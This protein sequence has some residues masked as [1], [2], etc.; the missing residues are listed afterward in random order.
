M[1]SPYGA[2]ARVPSSITTTAITRNRGFVDTQITKRDSFERNVTWVFTTIDWQTSANQG[3]SLSVGRR[4]PRGA[5][6][7]SYVHVP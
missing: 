4:L 3:G 5:R 7:H 1:L 6:T 2:D